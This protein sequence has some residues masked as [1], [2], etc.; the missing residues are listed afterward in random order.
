MRRANSIYGK[1]NKNM[2]NFQLNNSIIFDNY[3][4][5]SI[6]FHVNMVYTAIFKNYEKYL[7]QTKT[8]FDKKI[9]TMLL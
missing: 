6:S 4:D 9:T 3:P 1:I 2:C 7:M 8:T 5:N